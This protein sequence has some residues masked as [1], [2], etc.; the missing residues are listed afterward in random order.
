[1]GVKCL[2]SAEYLKSRDALILMNILCLL[3]KNN[4]YYSECEEREIATAPEERPI[5]V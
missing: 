5:F 2:N 3:N 1:M 4:I